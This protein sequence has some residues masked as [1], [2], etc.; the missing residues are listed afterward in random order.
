M[1][2][3]TVE[4]FMPLTHQDDRNEYAIK[5]TAD[6]VRQ[7]LEKAWILKPGPATE[8]GW[9]RIAADLSRGVGA[10]PKLLAEGT[11]I[12]ADGVTPQEQDM[13]GRVTHLVLDVPD[14]D[15]QPYPLCVASEDDGRLAVTIWYEAS[16][17]LL[18][19][20]FAT[21]VFHPTEE[22]LDIRYGD[23]SDWRDVRP[24]LVLS[25][26][27]LERLEVGTQAGRELSEV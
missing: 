16:D 4:G 24:E 2:C 14:A 3:L 23:G 26:I 19:K 17:F 20:L 13:K 10:D 12:L 25:R 6:A 8:A 22:A 11:G 18:G 9:E 15:G 1:L 27:L 5:G 21:A 7:L